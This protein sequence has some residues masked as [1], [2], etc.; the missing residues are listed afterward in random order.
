MK[1]M[2]CMKWIA[3]IGAATSLGS[4]IGMALKSEWFSAFAHTTGF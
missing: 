3:I 2:K 1:Y 4:A